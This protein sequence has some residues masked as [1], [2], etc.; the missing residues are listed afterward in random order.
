MGF[1]TQNI[2]VETD[3]YPKMKD[4]FLVIMGG[5]NPS[6]RN[7]SNNSQQIMFTVRSAT[8][9]TVDVDIKEFKLINHK[10]K[11]PG[12]VSW[13]PIK[14]TFVD[15]AGTNTLA[16]GRH[17]FQNTAWSLWDLLLNSGYKIPTKAGRT[18]VGK[19]GMYKHLSGLR[20]QQIDPTSREGPTIGG[21]TREDVA[22]SVSAAGGVLDQKP[23]KVHKIVE[24]WELFNPVIKSI[25]WGELSY[26]ED[27]LVEYTLDIDYDYAKFSY[28][29][30]VTSWREDVKEQVEAENERIE[31]EEKEAAVAA[32]TADN[33]AK[34][35]Q[36]T[37]Q[38]QQQA[39]AAGT[40]SN[41]SLGAPTTLGDP[42]GGFVFDPN[43]P[44]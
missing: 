5:T 44:I 4:R 1:W 2:N 13:Q 15:M 33:F 11:F 27:A 25:S 7:A 29:P 19:H 17:N 10:F 8:K 32:A 21:T 26:G 37:Q 30:P 24:E 14:L 39:A 6:T 40:L 20:I 12:V 41:Y 42:G 18:S 38:Q 43:Q 3:L 36:Q 22:L 35:R 34:A 9:P 23:A 16:L 28:Q 31:Q